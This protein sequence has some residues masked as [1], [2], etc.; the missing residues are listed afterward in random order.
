M[1]LTDVD[2]RNELLALLPEGAALSRDPDTDLAGL[3]WAFAGELARLD[4]AV[5]A[6]LDEIDP[7]TTSQLLVDWERI[8]DIPRCRRE[9]APTLD[10]RRAELLARLTLRG[11]LQPAF[12]QAVCNAAGFDITIVEHD[13]FEFGVSEFGEQFAPSSAWWT[14][15]VISPDLAVFE[16]EFGALTFGE[17]FGFVGNER[18]ACLLDSFKP[19][20]MNYVIIVGTP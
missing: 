17:P 9:Y 20:H 10:A 2:Y 13:P 19:A 5:E 18:L 15:D 16:A 14:F 6:L 4:C 7:R 8:T 1:A 12:I 3:L 11:S